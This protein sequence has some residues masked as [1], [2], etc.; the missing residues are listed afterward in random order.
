MP[1]LFSP[2]PQW[3]L[4]C[5]ICSFTKNTS[6]C[7]TKSR[8][9]PPDDPHITPKLGNIRSLCESPVRRP[10]SLH[11]LPQLGEKCVFMWAQFLFRELFMRLSFLGVFL[12]VF[13]KTET[14]SVIQA[15]MQWC[16][17]GSLQ[18]PPPLFQEILLPQLLE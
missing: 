6:L 17:L 18:P 12:V 5:H 11:C 9:S 13:F 1:S 7:F 14:H 4:L 16:H 10:I 8:N 2:I 15:G 3:L